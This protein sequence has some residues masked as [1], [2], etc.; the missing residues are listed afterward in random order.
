MAYTGEEHPLSSKYQTPIK[1]N[2]FSGWH[3]HAVNQYNQA[4]FKNNT[5][6]SIHNMYG[7]S[8]SEK[9]DS[10]SPSSSG[11]YMVRGSYGN[12]SSGI[13]TNCTG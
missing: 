5:R 2:G 1:Q 12:Q 10:I 3:L 13:V 7:S 6:N 11:P 9:S 8:S 4:I